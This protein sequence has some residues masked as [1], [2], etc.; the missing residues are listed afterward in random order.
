MANMN[1]RDALNKALLTTKQYI[2][3]NEP[4]KIKIIE[5]FVL[6]TKEEYNRQLD[7]SFPPESVSTES[8]T[9][10]S[11]LGAMIEINMEDFKINVND[12]LPDNK[13]SNIIYDFSCGEKT[14]S[15]I[16]LDAEYLQS[17]TDEISFTIYLNTDINFNPDNTKCRIYVVYSVFDDNDRPLHLEHDLIIQKKEIKYLD[18]KFLNPDVKI[19][20]SLTVGESLNANGMYSTAFGVHATA[21]GSCSHAEGYWTSALGDNAHAEGSESV[22]E[23]DSS[24]AEG[25]MTD[26]L[27]FCSHAEGYRTKA[28]SD[29]QH[30][31]GRHNI[32]DTEN[33]YLHIV[34]NGTSESK[35]NNAHTL[36]WEGN[37]WYQGQV[38]GTN[39]PHD[40]RVFEETSLTFNGNIEGKEIVTINY[41]VLPTSEFSV[42]LNE[43]S[44]S[45]IK[46]KDAPITFEELY[47]LS[48]IEAIG[49]TGGTSEKQELDI[50]ESMRYCVRKLSK[51]VYDISMDGHS[52]L[53]VVVLE[54]SDISIFSD[55]IHTETILTP[56]VWFLFSGNN[57]NGTYLS[58]IVYQ[59]IKSGE[60]K[61]LDEKFLP[62]SV[63]TGIAVLT[64]EDLDYIIN[65]VDPE[66]DS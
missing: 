27:G 28:S 44:M 57:T 51:N 33:K 25:V 37:A 66:M 9:G 22:A 53:V 55:A 62:D 31:Q 14:G 36:D 30:V 54:E 29:Y 3:E 46:V 19:R 60:L 49:I 12:I 43:S 61:K 48:R 42:K 41:E 11:A 34:G 16:A 4:A 64:E 32:E 15:I 17:M 24:H 21:E 45:Y 39:L 35:T 63:S 10:K 1:L 2:D 8:V 38:Q 59:G 56:G 13:N 40:T 18:N 65:N 58:K 50:D 5:E 47:S 7:I 52:S 20:R 6:M 26:A 23:G